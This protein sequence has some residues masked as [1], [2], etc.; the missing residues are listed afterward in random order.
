MLSGSLLLVLPQEPDWIPLGTSPASCS[1]RSFQRTLRGIAN[2]IADPYFVPFDEITLNPLDQHTLDQE[3][4]CP[5][6]AMYL[7]FQNY[8]FKSEHVFDPMVPEPV[9]CRN[10]GLYVDPWASSIHKCYVKASCMYLYCKEDKDYMLL[11]C[12]FIRSWCMVCQWRSAWHFCFWVA[13]KPNH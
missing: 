11:M 9:C 5:S 10:C 6:L 2:S 13:P 12:W 1:T 7:A 4:D 8:R 3:T